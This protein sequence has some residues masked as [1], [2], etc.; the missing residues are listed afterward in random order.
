MELMAVFKALKYAEDKTKDV[1]IITDSMYV[2]N[3]CLGYWK[4][5][6]NL[7]LLGDLDKQIKKFKTVGFQWV[8]GHNGHELNEIVDKLAK[9]MKIG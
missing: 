3:T 4:R 5:K 1:Y 6:V 2:I 8:K 9:G 7:K